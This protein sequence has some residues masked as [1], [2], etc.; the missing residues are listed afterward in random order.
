VLTPAVIVLKAGSSGRP[1]P[2]LSSHQPAVRRLGKV[3]NR[4][5]NCFGA[6]NK[7]FHSESLAMHIKNF[8]NL[9]IKTALM[10][11]LAVLT[12]IQGILTIFQAPIFAKL[13]VILLILMIA[14]SQAIRELS[15][16]GGHE[17]ADHGERR[18]GT[19]PALD[20]RELRVR[21]ALRTEGPLPT[22]AALN[23]FGD[24]IEIRP[25]RNSDGNEM[26][27]RYAPRD[28]DNQLDRQLRKTGRVLIVGS[29][30]SGVSRTVYELASR[31]STQ[32]LVFAPN[33]AHGLQAETM[34][35]VL[36]AGNLK[37]PVLLWLGNIN[38]FT[39]DSV[40]V[41]LLKDF[42]AA[43]TGSRI[44]ATITSGLDYVTWVSSARRLAD[45]F[46]EHCVVERQ[47]TRAEIA[48]AQEIYPDYDFSEGIAAPFT[49]V[50]SLMF[51]ANAGNPRCGR[52]FCNGD[53]VIA[54]A[55]VSIVIDWHA[56]GTL[57][58]LTKADLT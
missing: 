48:N 52:S 1:H 25:W 51:K 23:P 39:D 40:S 15:D 18:Q 29:P 4:L 32:Y 49:Y 55:V 34:Q 14:I 38:K 43:R 53:C 13:T 33:F 27:Q 46:D 31:R 5:E 41:G 10:V 21:S 30:I 58:P 54:R 57:R 7:A 12:A 8:R 26:L 28:V 42:L 22:F 35:E 36:H 6:R 44:I 9:P 19:G 24:L 45:F 16:N 47:L 11:D 50:S 17:P 2:T 37:Q 20:G 3:K 56:T